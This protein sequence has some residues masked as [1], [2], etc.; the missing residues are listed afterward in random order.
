MAVNHPSVDVCLLADMFSQ[1]RLLFEELEGD[2]LLA[3]LAL[4]LQFVTA[5][6]VDIPWSELAR[7]RQGNTR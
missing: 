7:L 5:R 6:Q 2:R 1:G 4:A 3:L